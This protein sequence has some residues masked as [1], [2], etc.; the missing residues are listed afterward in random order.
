MKNL[1]HG[2]VCFAAPALA[3]CCAVPSWAQKL[4]A[5]PANQ[6]GLYQRGEAMAWDVQATGDN[7]NAIKTVFYQIKKS[8]GDVVEQGTLTLENGAAR[9]TSKQDKPM[10][11]LVEFK[12]VGAKTPDGKEIKTLGGALM[13]AEKIA[14]VQTRPAD[15]DAFWKQKLAALRALPANPTLTEEP[16]GKDGVRYFKITLQ[17]I[18]GKTVYA[19]MAYPEKGAGKYPALVLLQYAGVYGLHKDWVTNPAAQGWLVI[20][21]MPHDLP[22]DQTPEFYQNAAQTT[23]KE[24]A[25]QGNTSR[26]TSYFLPM[27][28]GDIRAIDYLM[29]RAD[30]DKKTLLVSG[31]S[32]GGYQSFAVAALQPKVSAITVNVP[33]GCDLISKTAGR[34]QGW[35]YWLGW[36]Q[37]PQNADAM[38]ETSRYY[39][40][41]NFAPLIKV[42]AL[43]GLGL[44]D[45]T[46]PPANVYGTINNLRGSREVLVMP[47]SDHQGHNNTQAAYYARAYQWQQAFQKTGRAPTEKLTKPTPK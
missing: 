12:A 46:S 25:T 36:G 44:I 47:L 40:P 42:P 32:Q 8:G 15:F 30:W 18:N 4:E 5:A 39:D 31:T 37:A 2:A 43:V 23:L 20:N 33:A 14:P 35:P 3:L 11:Y 41:V 34:Q 45:E 9:L 19:Q 38:I 22:L 10:A 7:A 29:G 21:V 27:I 6:T 24:Y 26:D 16:S 28:L 17:N 1:L 13:E